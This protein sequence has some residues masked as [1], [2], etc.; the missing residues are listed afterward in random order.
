MFPFW[1][2]LD[3]LPKSPPPTSTFA[4]F[5]LMAVTKDD[6]SR[7]S[8]G[9]DDSAFVSFESPHAHGEASEMG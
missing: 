4:A 6:G 3:L 1:F 7:L 8:V 9:P 5:G 2:F